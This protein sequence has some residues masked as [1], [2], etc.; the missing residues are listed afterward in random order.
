MTVSN[1]LIPVTPI[2]RDS[3]LKRPVNRP[4]S[5]FIA[6]LIA[7]AAKAPQTRARRR[8]E[9]GEATGAYAELGQRPSPVGRI[10]SRSL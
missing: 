2:S 5:G 6:Q 9:P 4:D 3:K 1:F 7:T 10:L 8:A